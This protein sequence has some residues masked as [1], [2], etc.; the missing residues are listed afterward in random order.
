MREADKTASE[1]FGISGIV[2]MENAA[3]SCVLELIGFDSFTVL[4]GKG[5]NAGDGFAIARHLI[6][7][8]KSV[9]IYTL[10][11]EN[12]SGDS[13]TNFDILKN[14]SAQICPLD[15]DA[16][17]G[18]VQLTDCVIDAVFG[19]GLHGEISEEITEIFGIVNEYANYVLSVD[20]PSGID[21][22]TGKILGN[23]IKANKT[24]T[25]GA[26]KRGLLLFPA[27]DFAGEIK[28]SDISIPKVVFD[29][30]KVE[31]TEKARN[32]MPKR[33]NNSHKGDYGKVLII[34]G[35]VGM[36]G[37]VCLAAKAAFKMGA[38]L[39]TVCVPREINDI[40]Q[41]NVLEAMTISLDFESEQERIID[42]INDFDAVLFGNGIGRGNFVSDFLE[43]ILKAIKVPLI[44]DAD[45]L[46]ALSKKAE[47]LKFCGRD[48]ILTPHTMEMSRLLGLTPEKVEENRFEVSYNF[49]SENKLTLVLKGNHTI[50]TAPDG[51]QQV[52]MTGNSGMATAGSGD[53]LAGLLAGLMPTVK[54]AFDA[55][56]LAVYLHGKAGDFAKKS[57]GKI[58]LT[59]G[60]IVDS[61]SHILPVEM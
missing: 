35:S 31:V 54:N 10:L 5:N 51:A 21:A 9:K 45:G 42:E 14:M 53:V 33:Y 4:C 15:A 28:V 19:T 12:F 56:T 44:I 16:I 39:V 23:A 29:G 36:A 26:Y 2:L 17:K 11:G 59:A 49:A 37:A 58:S 46:F 13:N 30:V 20:V 57:I 8:G 27:A 52:N 47:L 7:K 38:G 41:K 43:K 6:N 22:D 55:A 1:K 50:I 60:D 48:V 61:I 32:L 18:D 40:V 25:F 3:T 24:V 34:G